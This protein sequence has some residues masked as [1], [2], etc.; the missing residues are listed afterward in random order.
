MSSRTN[1]NSEITGPDDDPQ[2]YAEGEIETLEWIRRNT[3][4][5]RRLLNMSMKACE[6]LRRADKRI[7]VQACL[8]WTAEQNG[9]PLNL[10]VACR[11][12]IRHG[13]LEQ[14]THALMVAEEKEGQDRLHQL[15]KYHFDYVPDCNVS[16]YN[17]KPRY[18][19]QTPGELWG[20]M[21]K[22]ISDDHADPH[23]EKPRVFFPPMTLGL[24]LELAFLEFRTEDT[25]KVRQE[26]Y[27]TCI[28]RRDQK[29]WLEPCLEG[30]LDVL[31]QENLL[32]D[33]CYRR[34]L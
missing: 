10:T 14:L 32:I 19:L 17:P 11:T 34:D 2:L 9:K 20:A 4:D 26:D 25:D 21:E 6:A 22:R 31:R 33:S 1:S 27:W 16:S 15:R 7:G 8:E 5:K 29:R 23:F 28:L 18:H 12:I 24:T 13:N 30:W 3:D